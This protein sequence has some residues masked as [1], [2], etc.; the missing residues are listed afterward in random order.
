MY[1]FTMNCAG[2]HHTG[3][4]GLQGVFPPLA[5]S[6]WVTGDE[7]VLANILLYGVEGELTVKGSAYKGSMPAFWRLSDGEL[8]ALATYAR[9]S[10]SNRATPV[11][12]DVIAAQRKQNPRT[13]PFAGGG[14]L[15]AFAARLR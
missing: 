9:S 7:R 2:C 4:D 1:L 13:K 11:T 14:E 6:E 8:A 15:K 10:W 5:G 3:G 12:P